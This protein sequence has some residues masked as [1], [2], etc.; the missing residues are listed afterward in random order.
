MTTD[1]TSTPQAALPK[2][3]NALMA[4]IAY[5]GPLVILSYLFAKDDSFVKFHIKQ[6]LVLFVIEIV[7]WLACMMVWGLWPLLQIINLACVVLA[8]IGIVR[9]IQGKE[10]ELPL[11]G[12][13]GHSFKI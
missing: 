5:V 1:N 11:V 12:K 10:T 13:F 3:H 7:L 4:A 8:I 9:A 2:G 6:G